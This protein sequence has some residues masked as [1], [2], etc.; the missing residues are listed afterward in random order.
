MGYH[1]IEP[2]VMLDVIASQQ[3]SHLL[4]LNIPSIMSDAEIEKG[5]RNLFSGITKV[6]VRHD[7]K[8]AAK[9]T[10][11]AVL[12]FPDHKTALTA[13]QWSGVG[14]VNL[15]RSFNFKSLALL[16]LLPSCSG[17]AT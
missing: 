9:G 3:R 11:T 12:E 10:C 2:G 17:T 7:P 13:K 4:A 16:M 8:M 6:C 1:I 14:S 15:V 5:F